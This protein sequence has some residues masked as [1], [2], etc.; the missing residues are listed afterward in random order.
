MM[1]NQSMRTFV[2]KLDYLTT[3]GWLDGP[4][5]RDVVRL[6]AGGGPYRVITQLG[7]YSFDQTAKRPKLL[8]LHP[9][10]TVDDVQANGQFEI[11]IPEGVMVTQPPTP[12][13]RRVLREI[14][15]EG[16]V[17]DK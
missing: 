10:I 8:S 9:G 3:P 1:R 16:I 12:G 15:R 13:E 17:L 7:V 2:N 5:R 6:P 11:L 14:G 4:G